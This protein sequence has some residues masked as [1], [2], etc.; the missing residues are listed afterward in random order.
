[1]QHAAQAIVDELVH[2]VK[3]PPRGGKN[4]RVLWYSHKKK[5]RGQGGMNVVGARMKFR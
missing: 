1:M 3:R 4:S 5:K 2:R